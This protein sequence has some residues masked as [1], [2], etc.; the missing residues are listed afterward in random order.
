MDP[1]S[2]TFLD[3]AL[4]SLP[5][6]G[7][8]TSGHHLTG[9]FPFPEQTVSLLKCVHYLL[10]DLRCLVQTARTEEW[11]HVCQEL[12]NLANNDL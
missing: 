1:A 5:L 7:C 6:S 10:L 8:Q 3:G 12:S 11:L 2:F 9:T 4:Y